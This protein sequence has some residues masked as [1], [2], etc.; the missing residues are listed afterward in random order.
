MGKEDDGISDL[1]IRFTPE[2][3]FLTKD[4]WKALAPLP[5][6]EPWATEGAEIKH[7]EVGDFLKWNDGPEGRWIEIK[8][9]EFEVYDADTS[10]Y[11]IEVKDTRNYLAGNVVVHNKA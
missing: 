5:N 8:E 6:Q 10:V 3:P 2:H 1:G 4:G 7:L 9:I 11:N